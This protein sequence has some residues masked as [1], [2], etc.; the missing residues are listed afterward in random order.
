MIIGAISGASWE[1]A[2]GFFGIDIAATY[3]G[4]GLALIAL[5][6]VQIID[7]NF[8]NKSPMAAE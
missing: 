7:I 5:F 3:V 8:L 1:L 4:V 2:N 6:G